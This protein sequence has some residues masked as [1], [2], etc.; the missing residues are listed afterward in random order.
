MIE[1]CDHE[2]EKL[3]HQITVDKPDVKITEKRKPIRY[4]KPKIKNLHEPL[5]KMTEGKD[6]MPAFKKKH[7]TA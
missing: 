3:L 4:N 7:Q 1:E 6:E 5:L 2:V